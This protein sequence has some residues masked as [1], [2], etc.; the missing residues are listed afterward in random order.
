MTCLWEPKGFLQLCL[1]QD[2]L[3]EQR[4]SLRQLVL[5][6]K[7]LSWTKQPMPDSLGCMASPS[8]QSVV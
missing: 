5:E 1:K 3:K 6:A 8:A 7:V 2:K 4:G